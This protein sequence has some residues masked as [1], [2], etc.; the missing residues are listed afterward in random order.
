MRL[1]GELNWTYE[2]KHPLHSRGFPLYS[3]G[4][5]AISQS[6]VERSQLTTQPKQ[7]LM[8][9]F[10]IPKDTQHIPVLNKITQEYSRGH[11]GFAGYPARCGWSPEDLRSKNEFGNRSDKEVEAFFQTWLYFG[12]I[13]EVLSIAEV[14]ANTGDFLDPSKRFVSSRNLPSKLRRLKKKAS[15][16]SKEWQNQ[17]HIE[18]KN[19]LGQLSEYLRHYCNS[20][21]SVTDA[22][23]ANWPVSEEISMSM[24]ALAYTLDQ[25]TA[26]FYGKPISCKLP[27]STLLRRRMLQSGW[28]PTDIQRAEKD[29]AID[30]H[31]YIATLSK[32]LGNLSHEKCTPFTCSAS[33]IPEDEY[34]V[35]HTDECCNC[36]HCRD[37][38]VEIDV[39]LVVKSLKAGG[40]PVV[41]WITSENRLGVKEFNAEKDKKPTYVAISHV[42]QLV[43]LQHMVNNIAS[44]IESPN[45]PIPFW[46]DTLCIPVASN[47]KQYRALSIRRMKDIYQSASAV[48]V[49]ESQMTSIPWEGSEYDTSLSIY[50]SN[51]NKRLWTFQEG[52]LA[53]KLMLQFA[54][55]ALNYQESVNFHEEHKKSIRQGHC[56]TFPYLATTSVMSEFVVLRDFINAGLFG[57]DDF[58]ALAPMVSRIQHRTTTRLSDQTLCACVVLGK[59]PDPLFKAG[60]DEDNRELKGEELEDRRMETFLK[61][62]GRFPP[63]VIFNKCPR[64]KGDGF[65]WGP[66]T[67][68][69]VPKDGFLEDVEGEPAVMTDDQGLAVKYAGFI[70]SKPIPSC[71]LTQARYVLP[72]QT[73]SPVQVQLE[74]H[75]NNGLTQSRD[76]DKKEQLAVIFRYPLDMGAPSRAS[77]SLTLPSQNAAVGFVQAIK[78]NDEG[79]VERVQIRHEFLAK[80]TTLNSSVLATN[81][82]SLGNDPVQSLLEQLHMSS[83]PPSS[84]TNPGSDGSHTVPSGSERKENAGVIADEQ[85]VSGPESDM[86]MQDEANEEV[87]CELLDEK[88]QWSSF[89]YLYLGAGPKSL[90]PPNLRVRS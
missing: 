7:Y 12:A 48:L 85:D 70:T 36:E 77:T 24:I 27:T 29:M 60:I 31:Y 66:R 17:W 68:L 46:I 20:S 61:M 5:D 9:H 65:R 44:H 64:L 82:G 63:S 78:R 11:G 47:L 54:D 45:R 58:Q 6:L 42:C 67:F 72:Q 13:I 40:F 26:D 10:P 57:A 69:G 37:E 83:P 49:V 43:R 33:S 8:D 32:P 90:L 86:K 80:I 62:V 87:V 16:T 3:F 59:D 74:M 53:Q 79:G 28:C 50:F 19:I 1:G 23:D 15:N 84:D 76:N 56:V 88:T 89:E 51:W 81:P 35:K 41:F 55:R 22:K 75:P 73:G 30:G 18:T 39:K 4:L 52:M 21:D 38:H 14:S 2:V 25:A 34:T 71:N